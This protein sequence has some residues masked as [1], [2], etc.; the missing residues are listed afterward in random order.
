MEKI[1]H[2]IFLSTF[3]AALLLLACGPSYQEQ[4]RLKQEQLREQHRQDSA[5]LKVA[6]MPT[7]DCLP[8]FLA[9][10]HGMF[11]TLGVSVRLRCFQAQMDCDTAIARGRVEMTVSDLVRTE[12]MMSQGVKLQYLTSTNAYWQLLANRSRRVR[13]LKQLDDK[14]VAMTRYSVTDMLCDIAIDSAKLKQE[15]VFKVQMND[16]NLRLK[17]LQNNEMDALVLTEPQ[18]AVARQGRHSLLLDTRKLHINMGVIAYSSTATAG[19]KRQQQLK[20]FAKAY[21]QAC[22]SLNS[23]GVG[24]Y[25]HLLGKYYQPL[26]EN[27]DSVYARLRFTRISPPEEKDV[28][29]ARTW[30]KKASK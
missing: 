7:L 10:D 9:Y 30:L 12:R 2:I 17:M 5:A 26:P 16:V 6:V 8:L 4:Q 21:N 1:H 19:K 23:R 29:R 25:R 28:E 13:E 11:D 27:I 15:R 22:D 14:M 3:S 24:A 18:A 20:L